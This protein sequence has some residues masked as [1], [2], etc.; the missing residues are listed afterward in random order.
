MAAKIILHIGDAKCGS[1]SIQSSMQVAQKELLE[2]GIL[3]HAPSKTSGH[4]SYITLMNGKTRGD[5]EKQKEIAKRNI[6]E[7]KEL[8]E[9]HSPKYIV[10]SAENFFNTHPSKILNLLKDILG[11]FPEELHVVA[12]VRHPISHYLSTIQQ[13]LKANSQFIQ[14]QTYCRDTASTFSRWLN[15]PLCTSVDARLFDRTRLKGGSTVTDFQDYLRGV[16]GIEN[17]ELED[18]SENNGLSTEQIIL[19]QRFRRDFMANQ[20]GR[21]LPESTHLLKLFEELNE[22]NGRI[23]SRAELLPEV[24]ACIGQQN[25]AFVDRLNELFPSLQMTGPVDE[26]DLEWAEAAKEWNGDVQSI[27]KPSDDNIVSLLADLIP[28]YNESLKSGDDRTA[29]KNVKI[30][31]NSK[32]ANK[33]LKKYMKKRGI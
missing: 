29:R 20:D 10:L 27:L 12:Y 15:E 16:T 28:E 1:S 3:Y 25:A 24:R 2:A 33:S 17:F 26:T 23:G 11:A 19:L 21:F 14:P 4:F 9:Q 8:I 32:A 30:L 31:T 7:I 13:M 22:I 6:S 5:N 18:I